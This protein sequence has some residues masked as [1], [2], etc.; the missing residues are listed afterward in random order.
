MQEKLENTPRSFL[1]AVLKFHKQ[2]PSV[3]S[4]SKPHGIV[5]CTL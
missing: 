2:N 1:V 5:H 4:D 3:N